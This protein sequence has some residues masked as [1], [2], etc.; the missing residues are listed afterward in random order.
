MSQ[1]LDLSA[2]G[3]QLIVAPAKSSARRKNFDAAQEWA[4]E[5]YGKGFRE[6]VLMRRGVHAGANRFV[7]AR[8][9][10]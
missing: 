7:P 9:R 1:R 5:R 8:A 2:D 4:H 6:V 10:A 3:R